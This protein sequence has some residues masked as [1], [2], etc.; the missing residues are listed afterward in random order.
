MTKNEKKIEQLTK[1]IPALK[2]IP[3]KE[4]LVVFYQAFRSSY[5]RLFL[6][7]VIVLFVLVFYVNL[8]KILTYKP[9]SRGGM[10]ARST[11]FLEEL[12]NSFFLPIMLIFLILV[13]GRS[14]FVKQQVKKY[15]RNKNH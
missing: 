10:I 8:D 13:L 9:L 6:T 5:Y 7:V 12:G 15:L 3:E 11:H 1:Q 2:Q 4:R 14:F